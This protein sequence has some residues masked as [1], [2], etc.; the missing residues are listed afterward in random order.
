MII[1]AKVISRSRSFQNQ[2]GS[3]WISI[4]KWAV[5]F[6]PDAFLCK[7]L[8]SYC[9]FMDN[10]SQQKSIS[11]IKIHLVPEM[12][13]NFSLEFHYSGPKIIYTI[14]AITFRPICSQ[15][16]YHRVQ[17]FTQIPDPGVLQSNIYVN[18]Y[19][20]IYK[21]NEFNS[22]CKPLVEA[23]SLTDILNKACAHTELLHN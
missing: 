9:K 16:L 17:L 15:Q 2:I 8:K 13:G 14:I 10:S 7:V 18:S 22:I 23:L 3:V 19:T 12:F 4:L 6:R 11:Q 20:L 21:S 1:K 5:C